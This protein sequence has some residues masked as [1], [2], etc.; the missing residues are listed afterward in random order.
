MCYQPVG[1]GDP[2]FVMYL[3]TDTNDSIASAEARVGVF[4]GR[5]IMNA[6]NPDMVKVDLVQTVNYAAAGGS[7]FMIRVAVL[8]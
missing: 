8:P 7:D 4:H 2:Y 6:F 1:L 5:H 3:A